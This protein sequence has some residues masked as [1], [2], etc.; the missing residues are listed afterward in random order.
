MKRPPESWA[1]WI[2]DDLNSCTLVTLFEEDPNSS[3]EDMIKFT[4]KDPS[5]WDIPNSN[6]GYK[7]EEGHRAAARQTNAS[8]V[9]PDE[10]SSVPETH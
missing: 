1:E 6:T 2:Q 5:S 9:E 3:E 8:A 4:H 10:L 7:Q